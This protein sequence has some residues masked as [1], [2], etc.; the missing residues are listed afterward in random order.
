MSGWVGTRC[1]LGWMGGWEYAFMYQV[2][3][4]RHNCCVPGIHRRTFMYEVQIAV[5]QVYKTYHVR[6]GWDTY[7][8]G[9]VYQAQLLCTRYCSDI[10][11]QGAV[12][13]IV[14]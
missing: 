14:T 7:V 13:P 10:F 5:Y 1:V 2:R 4:T 8:P 9:A 11:V 6:R 3:Y 12:Y